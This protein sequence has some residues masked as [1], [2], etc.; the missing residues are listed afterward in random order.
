MWMFRDMAVFYGKELLASCPNP[1]LEEH[2]LSALW[3]P[4]QYICNYLWYWRPFLQPQQEDEPRG[5]NRDPFAMEKVLLEQ[6]KIK[7]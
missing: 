2:P 1:S 6:K 4:I 3:L 7:L 5:G